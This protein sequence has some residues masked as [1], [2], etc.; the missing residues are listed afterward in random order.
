MPVKARDFEGTDGMGLAEP[1]SAAVAGAVVVV[2]AVCDRGF[3]ALPTSA[4]VTAVP[5]AF[6]EWPTAMQKLEAG[7]ETEVSPGAPEVP[8]VGS[9][10][11]VVPSHDAMPAFPPLPTTTHDVA[12]TQET[13]PNG[14]TVGV[15][16]IDQWL[17]SHT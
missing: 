16:S 14:G 7:H 8:T 9:A 11:Q 1:F 12:A 17:P 13:P 6:D 4:S 3:G 10:L 5:S 15:T 2:V